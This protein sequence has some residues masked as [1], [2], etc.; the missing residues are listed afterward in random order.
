MFGLGAM[1]VVVILM[2]ALIVLGP[3]KLP[4]V[5]RQLARYLGEL[6]RVADEVRRN[7]DEATRDD[8]HT[9]YPSIL[10]ADHLTDAAA[11]QRAMDALHE[12]EYPPGMEPPVSPSASDTPDTATA[13]ALAASAAEPTP[14][15][16]SAEHA[17]EPALN[18]APEPE[19]E[20][21]TKEPR[22]G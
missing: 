10:P 18:P 17:P 13:S 12:G 1:E 15:V 19:P 16:A 11:Q 7:F 22:H 5:A 14:P 21:K 3:Q 20:S 6:R 9:P 8:L 4:V 2:L